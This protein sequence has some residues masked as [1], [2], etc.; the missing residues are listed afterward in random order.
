MVVFC[1]AEAANREEPMI[2]YVLV[3]IGVCIVVVAIVL[4]WAKLSR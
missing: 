4:A 1:V 2:G 3:T